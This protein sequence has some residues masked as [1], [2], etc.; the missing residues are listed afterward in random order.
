MTVEEDVLPCSLLHLHVFL[1]RPVAPER[2]EAKCSC[3]LEGSMSGCRDD[4][5]YKHQVYEL[6][7]GKEEAALLVT[8]KVYRE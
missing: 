1:R 4:E 2:D 3:P 7:P 8:M 5:D 6:D